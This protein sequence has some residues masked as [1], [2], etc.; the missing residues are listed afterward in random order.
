[1]LEIERIEDMRCDKCGA[2]LFPNDSFC[3]SC[4]TKVAAY[5]NND[6]KPNLSRGA[7]DE[8]VI[9]HSDSSNN[10]NNNKALLSSGKSVDDTNPPSRS[11]ENRKS[12]SSGI[13]VVLVIVLFLLISFTV[14]N[15]LL[16]TDKI[17]TSKIELLDGYKESLSEFLHISYEDKRA[18]KTDSHELNSKKNES[19]TV[20]MSSTQPITQQTTVPTTSAPTTTENNPQNSIP[21]ELQKYKSGL[22][23]EGRT[24]R[25]KLKED[26]WKINYRSSPKFIDV[27]KS[28]NNILGKMKNGSEIFVEY[29][30]NGTW[31]VFYKDGRYVFS[32]L[33]ASN[34]P[35]LN[36]LMEVV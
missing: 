8:E 16:M 13:V 29:I 30:Y 27:N 7:H 18:E 25:V 35:S 23:Y 3:G 12:K 19:T 11:T 31:A 14:F 28:N 33:Y 36:R 24:Y 32:S 9:S 26:D 22:V 10:K 2:E 34:N 21:A 5:N 15:F 1:M 17:D 6:I 20:P 4:G